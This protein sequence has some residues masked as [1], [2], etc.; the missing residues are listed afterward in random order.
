MYS[1]SVWYL[2]Y[3]LQESSNIN[4]AFVGFFY[5][6]CVVL[7]QFGSGFTQFV[8]SRP[9]ALHPLIHR[10]NGVIL[11]KM[12]LTLVYEILNIFKQKRS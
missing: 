5:W 1:S 8:L 6:Q 4:R 11:G 2:V 12:L 10:K 7:L 9:P 3:H